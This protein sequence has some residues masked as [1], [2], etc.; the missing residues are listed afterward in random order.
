[1][2]NNPARP[3]A[4]QL[5]KALMK[6]PQLPAYV[7]QMETPVLNS[8]IQHVGKEDAQDLLVLASANQIREII[9]LDVWESDGPGMAECFSPSKFLEWLYIWQDMGSQYLAEKLHEL[10]SDLFSAAL[11][12]YAVVVDM[13]VVGVQGS[14]DVFANFGVLPHEETDWPPL[15][16]LLADVWSVD[17]ELLLDV[18]GRS[19]LRRSLRSDTAAISAEDILVRED[20]AGDR[21]DE[22]MQRG[23]VGPLEAAVMLSDAKSTSLENLLIEVAYDGTS[24]LHLRRI[25]QQQEAAAAEQKEEAKRSDTQSASTR[26]EQQGGTPTNDWGDIEGLLASVELFPRKEATALLEG[27]AKAHRDYLAKHLDQLA[28][29]DP[30]ALADRQGELVFLANTLLGG[31]TIQGEEVSREEAA[32]A[33]RAL[34]NLGL[35]YCAKVEAWDTEANV[36]SSFLKA[37]PGLV[38]AFRIGYHLLTAVQVATVKAL[39]DVLHSRTIERR[40]MGNTW[41]RE[42]IQSV[43]DP[44]ASI[45]EPAFE[46][47]EGLP[48]LI[49]SLGMTFDASTCH[50]LGVLSDSFPCFPQALD[51]DHD[52]VHVETAT[53]YV[54]DYEDLQRIALFL[55]NI[56]L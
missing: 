33:A 56:R 4:T 20:V 38:K 14:V 42:R 53:R 6:Q 18:L 49:E 8:L 12:E 19:C 9:A 22:Q 23:F 3:N 10:G 1:M 15:F 29:E 52:P 7:R 45:G 5:V 31:T 50:C 11:L 39:F 2:P 30:S 51:P 32:K 13:D 34:C 26:E 44:V 43:F 36:V 17:S 25:R 48:K 27:P 21:G 41:L 28:E 54:S 37:E 46:N 24:A 16:A 47:V 35:I 55:A 40:L